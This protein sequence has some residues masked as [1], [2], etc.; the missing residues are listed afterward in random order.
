[1]VRDDTMS[2]EK[3][4]LSNRVVETILNLGYSEKKCNVSALGFDTKTTYSHMSMSIIP[5]LEKLGII[6]TEKMGREKII[7][8]TAKGKELFEIFQRI[9]KLLK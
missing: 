6:T 9:E 2:L 1:M 5:H 8:L 4:I 3:D 7:K